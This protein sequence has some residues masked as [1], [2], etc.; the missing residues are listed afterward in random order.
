MCHN[1]HDVSQITL[2]ITREL[3][4]A[5]QSMHNEKTIDVKY[6]MYTY[7]QF[8]YTYIPQNWKYSRPKVQTQNTGYACKMHEYTYTHISFQNTHISQNWNYFWP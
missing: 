4:L 1:S 7:I 8:E 3:P 6:S 5:M 2:H